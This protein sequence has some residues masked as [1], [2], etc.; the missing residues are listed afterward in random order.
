VSACIYRLVPLLLLVA[1]LAVGV[2]DATPAHGASFT[3]NSTAD[4]VDATPGDGVCADAAGACTLRAAIEEANALP[5]ADVISVPQGIYHISYVSPDS[6]DFISSLLITDSVDISGAGSAQTV[7]VG[8]GGLPFGGGFAV[9]YQ[10][11]FWVT[12][13][14]SRLTVKDT[15]NIT[16]GGA[17]SNI[18][19]RLTINEV[20]LFGNGGGDNDGGGAYSDAGELTI[21]NSTIT[22][23]NAVRGGGVGTRRGAKLTITNS[24]ISG[25]QGNHGLDGLSS[26]GETV[27][28]SSTIL[29]GISAPN[30]SPSIRNSIVSGSNCFSSLGHNLVFNITSDCGTGGP[31]DLNGLDPVLG[32]LADNGGPTQTHALLAGS[33]AINAGDNNGC[34]ATDQRGVSRPQQGTCDIG[35]YEY[36]PPATPAPT[37]KPAVVTASPTP[38]LA[39]APTDSPTPTA[40]PSPSR[41]PRRSR[42]P[43][44][45]A[46]SA[47]AKDGGGAGLIIGLTLGG[48]A[49]A[50]AGGGG[51]YYL[52][53]RRAAGGSGPGPP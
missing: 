35:A 40:K 19:A 41:T 9:R 1:A 18:G 39:A 29:G 4:T 50:A 21:L 38:S 2:G 37:P 14:I 36:V 6:P 53:R 5:G 7:L 43:S 22:G 49:V 17:I 12:V 24:T 26:Q 32:P 28:E 30:T 33:P 13:T 10:T 44:A 52:W 15:T 46:P 48:L 45:T 20:A 23:N 25:N 31:G 27:I 16:G 11:Q 51:G 47:D 3:V 34:P 42:S 8:S